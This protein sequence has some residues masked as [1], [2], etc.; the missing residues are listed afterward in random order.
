MIDSTDAI[1]SK[2]IAY[3]TLDSDLCSFASDFYEHPPFIG[4]VTMLFTSTN[5][6]LYTPISSLPHTICQQEGE[7]TESSTV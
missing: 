5:K 1:S 3:C 4:C 2:A 6:N 7:M